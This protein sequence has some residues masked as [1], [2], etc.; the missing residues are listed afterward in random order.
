IGSN[1]HR[2]VPS[3]LASSYYALQN[4]GYILPK[5]S[6]DIKF[7]LGGKIKKHEIIFDE[8]KKNEKFSREKDDDP[9]AKAI[10]YDIE[11]LPVL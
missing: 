10:I 2:I 5:S 7:K 11:G 3:V 4:N 6:L 9:I 8:K 1:N